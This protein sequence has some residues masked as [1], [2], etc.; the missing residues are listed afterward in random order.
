MR[1]HKKRICPT[2]R[3][4]QFYRILMIILPQDVETFIKLVTGE[5][6]TLVSFRDYAEKREAEM[7]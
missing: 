6:F 3:M 1:Y 4:E 7:V 2:I 5:D